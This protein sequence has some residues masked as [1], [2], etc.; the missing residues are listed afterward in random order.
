MARLKA[1][2]VAAASAIALNGAAHAADLLPPPPVMQPMPPVAAADFG[3]WYLRGD[4]GTAINSRAPELQIAPNPLNGLPGSAFNAF[5][6]PTI[7]ASALFDIGVG[8]QFNSWL[9]ADVT[10]EYRG[11]ATFQA[12]EQLGVPSK[13][14]QFADFYRG[15]LASWITMVN[16]YADIGT[17]Y[18]ITPYVGAGIGMAYN[19]LSGVTDTGF[20]YP[21]NGAGYP[22]G[23]YLSNGSETNFAWAV[24][25][26][27]SFDVTQN[28]KLDL[29]YRYLDYGK[30]RTG[31]SHCF[32]GTGTGGG[33]S[34]GS[35]GGSSYVISSKDN[36]A[37]NDFRLG[38]RWMLGPPAPPPPA[39]PVVTRY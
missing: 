8:Y 33:F 38:L 12:L 30:I 22:T 1:L 10:E 18:G 13:K 15:G 35:C 11:G 24:M 5:Y 3:G 37:S 39:M 32:N 28:L 4:V 23:G 14:E 27:L 2:L 7:S 31:N 19:R 16:G 34:V 26:G 17:W 29:G 21:G 6:N 9:R 36:L 20:A 25:T